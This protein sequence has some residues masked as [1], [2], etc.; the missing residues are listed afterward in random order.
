MKNLPRRKY[1]DISAHFAVVCILDRTRLYSDWFQGILIVPSTYIDPS[2]LRLAGIVRTTSLTKIFISASR[3]V[4][5]RKIQDVSSL[6]KTR[7]IYLTDRTLGNNYCHPE[8]TPILIPAASTMNLSNAL[9]P[10]RW[11]AFDSVGRTSWFTTFA[12]TE[13]SLKLVFILIPP[14]L[15]PVTPFYFTNPESLYAIQ[16]FEH[17]MNLFLYEIPDVIIRNVIVIGFSL[18]LL[19][20]IDSV[21]SRIHLDTL[22][23]VQEICCG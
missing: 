18:R 3:Y 14:I 1:D 2:L 11:R 6:G 7:A 16:I 13:R 4:K 23:R 19:L 15:P 9:L 8:S 21:L 5:N 12:G 17:W 22:L 20:N 10:R